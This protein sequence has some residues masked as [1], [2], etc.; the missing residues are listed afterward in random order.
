MSNLCVV[1]SHRVPGTA[2]IDSMKEPGSTNHS[3]STLHCNVR[4]VERSSCL[5]NLAYQGVVLG[6]MQWS[7]Y[8][9]KTSASNCAVPKHYCLK[10]GC[11][12]HVIASID[13]NL[14]TFC[15]CRV[16]Y[17]LPNEAPIE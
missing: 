10:A 6:V 5:V 8:P 17:N 1:A 4:R 15:K 7:L 3:A 12:N 16:C 9:F 14:G 11:P 2:L 13:Y